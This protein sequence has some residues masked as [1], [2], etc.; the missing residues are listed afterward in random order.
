MYRNAFLM[1]CLF[2]YASIDGCGFSGKSQNCRKH[3]ATA[4]NGLENKSG[5]DREK[6]ESAHNNK[7]NKKIPQRMCTKHVEEE[8]STNRNKAYTHTHTAHFTTTDM[9]TTTCVFHCACV[10][11]CEG[12]NKTLTLCVA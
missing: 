10:C 6:K 2:E 5:V 3:R 4:C 9:D 11:V 12:R 7:N 1:I 8:F